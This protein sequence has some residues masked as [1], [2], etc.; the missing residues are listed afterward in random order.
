MENT[1]QPL[2]PQICFYSVASH[3]GGGERSMLDL[4]FS[5][6]EEGICAPWVLLPDTDGK[7]HAL[8]REKGVPV[9]ALPL[10]RLFQAVSR[11]RRALSLLLLLASLP[12]IC[13]YLLG[14]WKLLR[15][16]GPALLHTN[17]VKCHLLGALLGAAAGVPLVWHVRDILAGSF[18]KRIFLL[19]RRLFR[20]WIIC[21]STASA[22]ALGPC[23]R[24]FVVHN[25]IELAPPRTAPN[26]RAL[27]GAGKEE[28]LFGILGVLAR[29][30]GQE[31]FLDLG[32]ALVE[33]GLKVRLVVIGG[34]IYDTIGDDGF[35]ETLRRKA[36]ADGL[37]RHVH[38]TG[39]VENP[40]D[41]LRQLDCLVHC[42]LK[43][44]PFGRVIVEAM[45]C[46]VP[47]IAAG[48]GGVAEIIE[49]GRDGLLYPMGNLAALR[50]SALRLAGD[51]GFARF[52][53]ENAV[54]K[55]RERFSRQAHVKGV[56][57]VYR[58]ALP[59]SI[60]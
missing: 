11:E 60:F 36:A 17:G 25:G 34:R 59:Q 44:E 51:P 4:I 47:V 53:A 35:E 9:E 52:L 28:L 7:L 33:A 50:D 20:P 19:F 2:K 32:K 42:S 13:L 10:P 23:D 5:L 31:L 39:F 38:F 6:Q 40:Q 16:R 15:R 18:T 56:L 49:P 27:A 43:P 57:R 21:N 55:V 24:Q 29:W 1:Q 30:K 26:L 22:E 54:R 8:L 46:G 41:Y 48:A 58:Q 14:A 3:L 12:G 45:A 37:G